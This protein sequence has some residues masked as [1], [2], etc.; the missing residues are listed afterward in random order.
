MQCEI[1][2]KTLYVTI[3]QIYKSP[4]IAASQ[5]NQTIHVCLSDDPERSVKEVF[6]LT[7]RSPVLR[8]LGKNFRTG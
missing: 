5:F 7:H 2:L 3:W 1:S 8:G 6:I 4:C